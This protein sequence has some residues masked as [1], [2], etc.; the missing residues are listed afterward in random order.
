MK[1]L[2]FSATLLSM[3]AFVSCGDDKKDEESEE[4]KG[5]SLCECVNLD[6]S[7]EDK[8]LK[9]ACKKMQDEMMEKF[10]DASDEEK[11]EIMKEIEACK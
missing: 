3:M 5:P 1:K 4:A 6:E 2:L 10:K 11:E 9:E 7:T 8:D